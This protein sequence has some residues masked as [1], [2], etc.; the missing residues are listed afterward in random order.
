MK[1]ETLFKLYQ[2]EREYQTCCFGEYEELNS[3]NLASFL[4]FI[5]T[6]IEKSKKAYC[7]PWQPEFTYSEWLKN[8]KEMQE[9]SAP[10]KAYEELIKIFTL[11]GAALETF[12]DIDPE[13]W[14]ENSEEDLVKWKK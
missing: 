13:R 12:T 14:R 6:Y 10:E 9:G 4:L 7:G 11:A 8:C 2:K 3:L 1:L 5:E